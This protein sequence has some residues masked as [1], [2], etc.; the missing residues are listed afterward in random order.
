MLPLKKRQ[1]PHW[2]WRYKRRQEKL[3]KISIALDNAKTNTLTDKKIQTC[4]MELNPVDFDTGSAAEHVTQYFMPRTTV[5]MTTPLRNSKWSKL[6]SPKNTPSKFFDCTRSLRLKKLSMLSQA[7]K[8]RKLLVSLLEDF[9]NY[10]LR[11][12]ICGRRPTSFRAYKPNDRAWLA[13]ERPVL[14]KGACIPRMMVT[15]TDRQSHRIITL[16]TNTYPEPRPSIQEV[17]TLITF[18]QEAMYRPGKQIPNTRWR[19]RH[20]D[21]DPRK[22]YPKYHHLVPVLVVSFY[23]GGQARVLYGVFDGTLR[24]QYTEVQ[25]ITTENFDEKMMQLLRWALPAMHADTTDIVTLPAI[26]EG[27]EEE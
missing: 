9:E 14:E 13:L 24:I 15:R 26:E 20:P 18:I 10:R 6:R 19:H 8:D 11:A 23:L 25:R 17:E 7:K 22:P 27:E 1:T 16:G 21:A 12:T 2:V 3:A 4:R 5:G